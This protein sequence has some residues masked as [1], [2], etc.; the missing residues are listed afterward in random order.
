MT[1]LRALIVN[2]RVMA[3]A[4]LLVLIALAAPRVGEGNRSEAQA[5]G[6]IRA[7]VSA[8]SGYASA[9][10]GNYGLLE[11]LTD[12]SCKPS[13]GDHPR[14]LEPSLA[15]TPDRNGYH[16][17]FHP[18]PD[19]A[20]SERSSRLALARFAVVAV[21]AD[22]GTARGRGFCADD[23]QLIYVTEAGVTPRAER[24]R[25]IDTSKTLR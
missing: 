13:L 11:C 3:A 18:D 16:F 2:R 8:E 20:P 1:T 10:G 21:P 5:I 24:G 22:A 19:P 25:C 7:I 12:P 17:E 6:S 9:N 4:V 15:T 23:R 14:F